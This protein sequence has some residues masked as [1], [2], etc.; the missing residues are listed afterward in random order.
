MRTAVL[1][2]LAVVLTATGV[3]AQSGDYDGAA[4]PTPS[5][6]VGTVG[7]VS[8]PTGS[9]DNTE[10]GQSPSAGTVPS[11]IPTGPEWQTRDGC[12][13]AAH[14]V[15]RGDFAPRRHRHPEY[16]LKGHTHGRAARPT[17]TIVRERVI[18]KCVP[19][20]AQKPVVVNNFITPPPAQA[21]AA[22]PETP[23]ERKPSVDPT[24]AWIIATLIIGAVVYGCMYRVHQTEQQ[25][26]AAETTRINDAAARREVREAAERAQA[27]ANERERLGIM[28][29]AVGNQGKFSPE[30][31]P[32]G[33]TETRTQIDGVG[34]LTNRADNRPGSGARPL[35]QPGRAA[36]AAD[37]TGRV[38]DAKAGA[39][40]GANT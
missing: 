28:R 8:G 39:Q 19:A 20:P 27:A 36:Q 4:D 18:E 34:V 14:K 16:A 30:N 1:V 31:S 6:Q 15:L 10:W 33:L 17:R 13:K 40:A 3:P 12:E 21:P 11:A 22:A 2:V 38:I 29:E 32:G 24:M 25:R 37:Q 35:T 23:G 9:S 26:I 7:E 5:P